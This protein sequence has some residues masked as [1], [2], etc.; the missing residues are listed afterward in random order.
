MNKLSGKLSITSGV[1]LN[2]ISNLDAFIL[3]TDSILGLKRYKLTKE[4]NAI[5]GGLLSA[6]L[7]DLRRKHTYN[8]GYV[9][10]PDA[11][12]VTLPSLNFGGRLLVASVIPEETLNV[13]TREQ[14]VKL[15]YTAYMTAFRTISDQGFRTILTP[16]LGQSLKGYDTPMLLFA[17]LS[18][19][20][21]FLKTSLTTREI[22]IFCRTLEEE[23]T[24][25]SW[26]DSQTRIFGIDFWYLR[27][28]GDYGNE[29]KLKLV[30]NRIILR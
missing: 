21:D 26:F 2:A 11:S 28:D 29:R 18:A 20:S 13:L 15:L 6:R 23:K 19:V 14:K 10:F 22:S 5:E 25:V 27:D 8:T 7:S 17:L 12:C 30:A 3:P 16:L 1:K 9:G 4:M 24:L